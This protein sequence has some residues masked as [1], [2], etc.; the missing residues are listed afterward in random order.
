MNFNTAIDICEQWG[1]D[2]AIR[3]FM[4]ETLQAMLT[5]NRFDEL[6]ERQSQALRTVMREGAKLVGQSVDQ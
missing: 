2:N 5:A 4:L 3:G 1:Q 6:S